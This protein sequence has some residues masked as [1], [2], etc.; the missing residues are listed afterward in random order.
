MYAAHAQWI[1]SV[2]E[3]LYLFDKDVTNFKRQALIYAVSMSDMSPTMHEIEFE[4]VL[5]YYCQLCGVRENT[6]VFDIFLTCQFQ[7][8]CRWIVIYAQVTIPLKAVTSSRPRKHVRH[9]QNAANSLS[10]CQRGTDSEKAVYLWYTAQIQTDTAEVLLEQQIV[11]SPAAHKMFVTRSPLQH[12]ANWIG[13]LC[14]AVLC[15]RNYSVH[16]YS[17]RVQLYHVNSDALFKRY[18]HFRL[19]ITLDHFTDDRSPVIPSRAYCWCIH[20]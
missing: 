20:S 18:V 16:I 10:V 6:S 8:C 13:F 17:F 9:D 4:F 3:L 19:S 1:V 12:H 15:S 11:K 5:V 14:F 2:L 7:L